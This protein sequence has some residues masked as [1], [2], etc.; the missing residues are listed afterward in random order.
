MNLNE[1][2]NLSKRTMPI[3]ED[4]TDE[5]EVGNVTVNYALGVSGEAG[6]VA[7][8]VKKEVFHGHEMDLDA[9]KKELGDVL[10]YVAGIATL[11]GLELEEVAQANIDKLQKRYPY[12]FSEEDSKKRVDV[13]E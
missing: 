11:Y 12:G 9:I 13:Y 2:Q 7:D 8:Q 5:K 10:H 4:I 3:I 1:Y 6:E